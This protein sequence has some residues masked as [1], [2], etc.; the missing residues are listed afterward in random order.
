MGVGRRAL[1]KEYTGP[2]HWPCLLFKFKTHIAVLETCFSFITFHLIFFFF[3]L[4]ICKYLTS[5]AGNSLLFS[6]ICSFVFIWVSVRGMQIHKNLIWFSLLWRLTEASLVNLVLFH[7]LYS[8]IEIQYFYTF[9]RLCLHLFIFF[10]KACSLE[11][12]FYFFF[13]F[14]HI[15]TLVLLDVTWLAPSPVM[16]GN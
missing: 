5:Q 14:L 15:I 1:R 13:F 10:F 2:L 6:T 8:D 4:S 11:C 7:V 9:I 12:L 16:I 3:K